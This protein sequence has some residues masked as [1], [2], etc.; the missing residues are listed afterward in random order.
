M[1]NLSL[2]TILNSER[3]SGGVSTSASI[4]TALPDIEPLLNRRR[5][6]VL[7]T[8]QNQPKHASVKGGPIF[9]Q[10]AIDWHTHGCDGGATNQRDEDV[11]LARA[12]ERPTSKQVRSVQQCCRTCDD[13][14]KRGHQVVVS[15]VSAKP[16]KS[17]DFLI[18]SRLAQI[19]LSLLV[20]HFARLSLFW[21]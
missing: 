4:S 15:I 19:S 20:E 5:L 1:P 18:A 12:L 3:K 17:C 7:K 16:D 2:L 13:E 21:T 10:L 14:G 8:N 6:R 9:R 11:R